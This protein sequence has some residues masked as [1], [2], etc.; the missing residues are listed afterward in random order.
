MRDLLARS[1][2][3]VSV[4]LFIGG[5]WTELSQ[6]GFLIAEPRPTRIGDHDDLIDHP[7]LMNGPNNPPP[8]NSL[9][10]RNSGLQEW[11]VHYDS[12]NDTT[13]HYRDHGADQAAEEW[14][15][16]QKP[17]RKRRRK[18]WLEMKPCNP[19]ILAESLPVANLELSPD[20][21]VENAPGSKL[22]YLEIES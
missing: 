15:Q 11:R 5:V 12:E 16:E 14:I 20:L 6:E 19:N 22:F 2:K 8:R 7:A 4:R 17:K 18:H 21:A 1:I 13:I 9:L 3:D 10:N